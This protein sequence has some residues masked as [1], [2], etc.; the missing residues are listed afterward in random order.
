MCYAI[1]NCSCL[2]ETSQTSQLDRSSIHREA[3]FGRLRVGEM[4]LRVWPSPQEFCT[5]KWCFVLFMSHDH[6][7]VEVFDAYFPAVLLQEDPELRS[8]VDVF[9]YHVSV[10][11]QGLQNES[12]RS[13]NQSLSI[14]SIC[15]A[16]ISCVLYSLYYFVDALVCTLFSTRTPATGKCLP[17]LT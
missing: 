12:V 15:C 8:V 13:S 14:T 2:Q 5:G 1:C 3:T 4:F 7:K 11:S 10:D 6:V 17:I 16:R 9:G